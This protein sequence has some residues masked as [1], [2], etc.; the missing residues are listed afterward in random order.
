MGSWGCP[1]EIEGIC[2]KVAKRACDPGM[3]GCV[4]AGR[5]VFANSEDKNC[6]LRQHQVGLNSE[7]LGP[8]NSRGK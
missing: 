3:R 6:R 1:H 8:Y 4:L 2:Q 7:D 5:Y